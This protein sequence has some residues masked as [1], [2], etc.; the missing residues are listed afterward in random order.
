MPCGWAM[1]ERRGSVACKGPYRIGPDRTTCHQLAHVN[2]GYDSRDAGV[3]PAGGLASTRIESVAHVPLRVGP[4]A[5]RAA[6]AVTM[7][8]L[9][10]HVANPVPIAAPWPV[11]V[12]EHALEQAFGR[13]LDLMEEGEVGGACPGERTSRKI[14]HAV[15]TLQPA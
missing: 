7:V 12:V 15:F 14:R 4:K 8:A 1:R 13:A 2:C 5:V 6:V 11:A 9:A 3:S 10:S